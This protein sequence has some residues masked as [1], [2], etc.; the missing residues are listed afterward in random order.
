MNKS[1]VRQRYNQI[2]YQINEFKI[3]SNEFD[4]FGKELT[5]ANAGANGYGLQCNHEG[6]SNI[7]RMIELK[8][9]EVVQLLKEIA[10]LNDKP[11]KTKHEEYQN[12]T[13]Q[14]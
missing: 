7:H 1:K 2:K 11:Q 5:F 12:D 9:K 10:E 4:I 3:G 8:C 14:K 13:G 6:G